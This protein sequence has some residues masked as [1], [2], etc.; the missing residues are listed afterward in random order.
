MRRIPVTLP[1]G[2]EVTLSPGGQ[3]SLIRAIVEEF[4]SRFVPGGQVLYVGDAE[5]KFA[6]WEEGALESAGVRPDPHGKMPDV[7][8]RD[9]SRDWLIVIE[10]VTSHGPVDSKRRQELAEIFQEAT[11]GVLY[12]S[13]F[14][15]RAALS[16]FINDI[17]WET[18]VWLEESP[19]H[20]I[21]FD[22][23]R[24]LGPYE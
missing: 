4:C 1:S 17:S 15:S 10:A 23:E 9:A 2:K 24:F 13:A 21:H 8:V 18:D 3:N 22:G 12:V 5:E 11:L 6:I 19:T 20:L 16:E 14:A 7:I